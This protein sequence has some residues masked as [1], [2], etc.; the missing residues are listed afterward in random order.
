MGGP[1][2][3]GGRCYQ[4]FDNFYSCSFEWMG[5]TWRSAEHLYQ[6]LKFKDKEYQREINKQRNP[7]IAWS[8]GQSRE[9]KLIDDFE[10]KKAGLMYRANYEKFSQNPDLMNLLLSTGQQE[11]V[12]TGSTPYWNSMNSK[13]LMDIR[14]SLKRYS[15]R[16]L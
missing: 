14:D 7:H 2:Y 10:K 4:H 15:K 6:A 13:I 9:Y 5:M 12:S 16:S 3:V 8:M 11:I 1:A